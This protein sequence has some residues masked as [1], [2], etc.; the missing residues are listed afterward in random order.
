MPPDEGDGVE[1]EETR[2]DFEEAAVGCPEIS[3]T[4]E[5]DFFILESRGWVGIANALE[6]LKI[7]KVV[8][9]KVKMFFKNPF[10]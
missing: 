7:I 6:G 1:I 8:R 3:I 5:R 2:N 4:E 10:S 9:R